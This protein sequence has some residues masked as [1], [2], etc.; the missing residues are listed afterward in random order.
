MGQLLSRYLR[1]A[2]KDGHKPCPVLRNIL[3]GGVVQSTKTVT[4]LRL[5]PL[6]DLDFL[7]SIL[8]LSDVPYTAWQKI[9]VGLHGE[10]LIRVI[11]N[12]ERE[13]VT[14]K[15]ADYNPHDYL[16]V[17]FT[18]LY[19]KQPMLQM[20]RRYAHLYTI[21]TDTASICGTENLTVAGY[22]SDHPISKLI[23]PPYVKGTLNFSDLRSRRRIDVVFV[24]DPSDD[25]EWAVGTLFTK[26]RLGDRRK[27]FNDLDSVNRFIKRVEEKDPNMPVLMGI[28]RCDVPESFHEDTRTTFSGG[29]VPII[30]IEPI[31]FFLH[32]YMSPRHI[33]KLKS[34]K[35]SLTK[36]IEINTNP[37]E[38]IC[39][40]YFPSVPAPKFDDDK[41]HYER[42]TVPWRIFT[43][44]GIPI[45][46]HLTNYRAHEFAKLMVTA[47]G[48][49][50]NGDVATSSP[51]GAFL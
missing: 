40:L 32:G 34:R 3:R 19:A 41:V 43:A 36:V 42:D 16:E 27:R 2:K 17:A 20:S 44:N 46:N 24:T 5:D 8:K 25:K 49:L 7:Y 51:F 18:G 48:K 33:V 1:L 35:P 45:F 39:D 37:D 50:E 28:D 6:H 22:Y 38:E 12:G 10:S 26:N 15:L 4:E 29:W 30:P 11:K 21:V 9:E 31:G 23:K 14:T 13:V 47:I